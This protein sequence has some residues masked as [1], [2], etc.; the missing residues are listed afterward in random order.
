MREVTVIAAE[1]RG[2]AGKGTARAAR[3]AGRIPAVVYGDKKAPETISVDRTALVKEINRG[4]FFNRLFE[5]EVNGG[6]QSVLA[7][8]VQFDPVSDQPVHVDFLRVAKDARIRIFVPVSF[9]ESEASPGIK[10]GGVLN[11][12]R[13]EIEFYCPVETIPEAITISIAGREIGDSIHI[14]AVTLPEGVRPVIADRDFTIATIAAPTLLVEA[15]E[16][17]AAAAVPA[18]GEAAPAAGEAKAAEAK[19]A[20]GAEKGKK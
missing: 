16:K 5:I 18:E 20:A 4:H 7:R 10:R 14:S 2:R 8:D 15:E 11:V 1:T 9:V 6:K 19:P 13:H 3:R 17:P 12:V